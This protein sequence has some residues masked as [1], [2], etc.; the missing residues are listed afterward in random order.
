VRQVEIFQ[1]GEKSERK[2]WKKRQFR[3]V[4]VKVIVIDATGKILCVGVCVCV[5]VCVCR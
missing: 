5:C 1:G 3:N 2:L 4:P